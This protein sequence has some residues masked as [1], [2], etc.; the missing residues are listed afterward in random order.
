MVRIALSER[1]SL[2]GNDVVEGFID[3][4]TSEFEVLPSKK[5]PRGDS[6][7]LDT[8]MR[9]LEQLHCEERDPLLTKQCSFCVNN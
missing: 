5:P 8:H 6:R 1:V 3:Q 7:G 4:M 2:L 9:F